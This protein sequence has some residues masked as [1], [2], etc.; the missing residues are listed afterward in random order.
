MKARQKLVGALCIGTLFATAAC[1]TDPETGERQV[2][3]AAIGGIGGAL[4]GYLL[5][6]LVGGKRDR[7]EKILGAGIGAVA[8]A[9]IG[10]YMD[11]QERKLRERTAGT[12]VD[13]ERDGD[14]LLLRMPSGITFAY[15][16][17]D[18]MPQFQPTL[19]EVAA[20]LAEFPKT[21]IDIYGHTDSDGS[22]SYN[23][24][25]SER[26]AQ[27]VSTYLNQHGVQSARMATR[28]YGETQPI[29][30][31]ATEAG[32]AAN[33]RVEIKIVPVTEGDLRG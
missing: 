4:G 24:M 25:L 1:T 5:G 22:D 7:T 31:N 12:G 28:G 26:R 13:V 11:A 32:K 14:N 16:K 6:D 19:N 21:Y 18:V 9:G 29:A 23:Q 33:R 17:A 3:K 20:T 30:T 15:D 27:A 8:G 10:S 2:S